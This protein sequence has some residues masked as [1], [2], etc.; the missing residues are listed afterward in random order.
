LSHLEESHTQDG[1]SGL[2]QSQL[3]VRKLQSQIKD[4]Q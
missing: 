2:Q 1:A 4:L 3:L